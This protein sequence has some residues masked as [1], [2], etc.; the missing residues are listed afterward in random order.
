MGYRHVEFAGYWGRSAKE[1]RKLLDDNGLSSCGTHT[2]LADLQPDKI[3]ATIEFHQII[4]SRRIICPYMTGKTR[5]DWMAQVKRFNDLAARLKPL[6]LQTGYH[7]HKQ[8]FALVDDQSAWDIFF[9]NTGADVIMQLDTSN[10]RDGGKDPVAV[11]QQYPGRCQS[12]HLKPNGGGPES[13]I[14]EDKIDWAGVFEWCKT[15]GGT[16]V[17]VVEHESSS[18]PL[19]TVRRMFDKLK[20]LG[21]A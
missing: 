9:T 13:V 4:G 7:A 19:E 2:P 10:C 12:I 6:G 16:E 14:G 5:A 17:Y 3:E 21:N 18:K 20:E 11:L 8:D 15:K 1:V